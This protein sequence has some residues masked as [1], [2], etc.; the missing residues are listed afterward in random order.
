[1]N[2]SSHYYNKSIALYKFWN[3]KWLPMFSE[4]SH[5]RIDDHENQF[6]TSDGESYFK[7]SDGLIDGFY[8]LLRSAPSKNI[9]QGLFLIHFYFLTIII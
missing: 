9:F 3:T 5:G 2:I 6:K 7:S 8:N 4:N 1:M